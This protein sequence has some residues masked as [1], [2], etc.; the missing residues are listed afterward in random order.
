MEYRNA[1][2]INEPQNFFTK[3]LTGASKPF[4]KGLLNTPQAFW[5]VVN[6]FARSQGAD[7]K[8]FEP[9]PIALTEQ[10]AQRFY[11][12]PGLESVK[13]GAGVLSYATPGT[14]A[15]FLKP[16]S[17]AGKLG[18]AGVRG[19]TEGALQGF[20]QSEPGQE[21]KSTAIGAGTGALGDIFFTSLLDPQV[22]KAVHGGTYEGNI[23]LGN[24]DDIYTYEKL[25]NDASELPDRDIPIG[26]DVTKIKPEAGMYGSPVGKSPIGAGMGNELVGRGK[27]VVNADN[28][29][30]MLFGEEDAGNILENL[31]IEE[32]AMVSDMAEEVGLIK[33][34]TIDQLRKRFI[35]KYPQLFRKIVEDNKPYHRKR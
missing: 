32:K 27:P 12:D 22:R 33:N 35:K 13:S 14:F 30:Q 28:F 26:G 6:E 19:L 17:V 18:T 25:R 29:I 2:T 20:S 10:E 15:K 23:N 31:D 7:I 8:D 24:A 4:R 21:L 11:G 34:E 3:L 1:T 5:D 16:T 9:Q